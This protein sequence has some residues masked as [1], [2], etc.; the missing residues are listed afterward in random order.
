MSNPVTLD[1]VTPEAAIPAPDNLLVGPHGAIHTDLA[2]VRM[3]A[4]GTLPR[5]TLLM[6]DV[7]ETEKVFVPCAV[8]GLTLPAASISES[9]SGNAET[10][11][12]DIPIPET[13]IYGILAD[14]V[15]LEADEHAE[16]AIYFEGDFNSN[17]VILP[18]EIDGD[19]HEE[20][21]ELARE[22][23][24]RQKIFLRNVHK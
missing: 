17:A 4:G 3:A 24:R 9:L 5:G 8:D 7:M 20:Q 2:K 15:T 12:V 22:P 6:S 11:A 23:L 14:T 19:D 10:L 21:I 18:W 13:R 16:T 1:L